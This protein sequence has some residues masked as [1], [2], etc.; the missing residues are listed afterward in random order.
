M[1]KNK[2][3]GRP[4]K[5]G[6]FFSSS[7][8]NEATKK[9]V[10]GIVFLAAS[11]VMLL[12]AFSSAGP[13]GDFAYKILHSLLGVGYYLVPLILLI[14]GLLFLFSRE[15]KFFGVIFFG[16]LGFVLS[17]L[18]II[19]VIFPARAG[20]L[21]KVVGSLEIPFGYGASIILL[22]AFL[23]TSLLITLNASIKFKVPEFLKKPEVD[24]E[25]EEEEE[26][27]AVSEKK[28]IKL[29][30]VDS[31]E[32][33][34]EDIKVADEPVFKIGKSK[35]GSIKNYVPPP[36]DLL[37]SSTAKPVPGDL[38]AN[39]NIIK[40]TLESFGV[41]VEMGE[42]NIG[43]KVT[44]YT[45]KPA[46]GV[47]INKIVSLNKDLS[48]A[49]A[50]HPIRIEAP[51]PGKSLI[52]IEVPNKSA[53]TVHLGNMLAYA[54]F[55]DGSQLN[56]PAGRD[57]SGEPVYTDI[58]K[59]PHL[60]VAGATGS[61]KSILVHSIIV[62][63]L[64]KNSP[65]ML[66][67]IMI[68]PKRVE[69]TI[70]E[71]IPHL[72]SPV[73]TEGKKSIAVFRWS[74][75]EM[76][77]RYDLL[78]KDGSR[79]IGSYNKKHKDDPLPYIMIV[80]DELAD[81]MAAF[82]REVEGYIVR[83]AQMARATG[84][85]LVLATQRPSVEVVT[86]L[87]KANIPGRVALQV[88]SQIDSRTIIDAA[89]AEK[90][91]GSGDHLF[92]SP[93]FSKPVRIQGCYVSENEIKSV[94]KFIKENNAELYADEPAD[95]ESVALAESIKATEKPGG[96]DIFSDYMKSDDDDD[97]LEDAVEVIKAADKA[98]ASLLQRRLKI[99][100][101]RAARILDI[102]EEKGLIGPADGA[103]P[104]EVYLDNP[105]AENEDVE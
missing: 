69:L 100:Y 6:S 101:A 27:V 39:A 93:K 55:T 15:E 73:I 80:I 75:S 49:L 56:F 57:V 63:L 23:V 91:L 12:A 44:R 67:F 71:G 81:L 58:E 29:E 24:E 105:D 28:K 40:R 54:S 21:G 83:L 8:I 102:M 5:E 77:R 87:I 90:L 89:G 41:S 26:Y 37:I 18:G 10:L 79:D 72:I 43:P 16:V 3:R 1:S 13:A 4:R 103:K 51:I 38:R 59:L 36:I 53:A 70:Y 9:S 60:L 50:A 88:A 61:G 31:S 35:A 78:M 94:V 96:E 25:W 32:K 46:Q 34:T 82:G 86:G 14:L 30:A 52:G 95:E 17:G 99:G 66:K 97:L 74:I 76:D 68:D 98:S 84:I 65:D 7:K 45:L 64:Y 92:I 20:F 22:I 2:K 47:K 33:K 62:S 11:V 48:L 85:H 19:D 104:R 42:I